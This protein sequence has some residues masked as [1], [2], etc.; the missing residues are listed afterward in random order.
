MTLK[1]ENKRFLSIPIRYF[2][3]ILLAIP[4]LFIF[5]F[6][7]TPLTIYPVYFLLGLIYSVFLSGTT[8][9]TAGSFPI[10][11]IRACVAGSAYF[12]LTILNLTTPNIKFKKRMT[13]LATSFLALLLI[14]IIRIF[15][16]GIMFVEGS[17]N[18]DVAHKL[19]WYLGSTLFVVIIWFTQVK[20]FRIKDTPIYSDI[21]FLSRQIR[22]K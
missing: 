11:I 22:K 6:I 13:I 17:A 9:I 3:L 12:L 2:S 5:Y 4:N 1:M 7:F 16:L 10:E 8:I 18:L 15:V 19:F 21:R 14:N 20:I